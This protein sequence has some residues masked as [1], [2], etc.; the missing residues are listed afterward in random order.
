MINAPKF[1]RVPGLGKPAQSASAEPPPTSSARERSC[2]GTS[3]TSG[4]G[5]TRRHR[6]CDG[7][8]RLFRGTQAPPAPPAR[9]KGEPTSAENVKIIVYSQITGIM[10]MGAKI[11]NV[12]LIVQDHRRCTPHSKPHTMPIDRGNGR[13]PAVRAQQRLPL[14]RRSVLG[15]R[16]E[17]HHLVGEPAPDHRRKDQCEPGD[18][19]ERQRDRDHQQ[20]RDRV[21]DGPEQS[22]P[23]RS[24]MPALDR[25]EAAPPDQRHDGRRHPQARP[26]RRA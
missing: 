13:G 23:P 19:P 20:R 25:R 12:M 3:S 1:M 15:Q 6:R 16:V 2:G 4:S 8:H 21:D 11:R 22:A 7:P 5:A 26:Q 14:R 17:R 24:A 10:M 18:Q 9:S